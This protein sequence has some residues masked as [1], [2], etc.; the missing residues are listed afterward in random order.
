MKK[1]Q[2]V[3]LKPATANDVKIIHKWWSDGEIMKAVGF[4]NG[5][6]ITN[7]EVFEDIKKYQKEENSEFLIILNEEKVEIGEFAYKKIANY[8]Y[9]F[10]IKIGEHAYQGQGYGKL[11]LIKGLSIIKSKTKAKRVEISVD[12]ENIKALK[13]YKSVGFKCIQRI[14]NNWKNQLG[15]NCSTEILELVIN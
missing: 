6:S 14:N 10:D 3:F 12:S 13:L 4:P 9:T 8:T 7:E 1:K 5:L 2:T 11:A 15:E